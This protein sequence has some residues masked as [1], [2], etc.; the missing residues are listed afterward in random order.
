MPAHKEIGL[1]ETARGRGRCAGFDG[2][3]DIP[4]VGDFDVDMIIGNQAALCR[5][6][7]ILP[8]GLNVFIPMNA[9]ANAI[10][11]LIAPQHPNAVIQGRPLAVVEGHDPIQ[12][13]I[14][15][16][17]AQGHPRGIPDRMIC[18]RRPEDANVGVRVIGQPQ[19]AGTILGNRGRFRGRE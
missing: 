2:R 15:S 14:I 6:F 5:Y 18:R 7:H 13:I 1:V 4:I 3:Q 9:E 17:S 19:F 8:G 12:I 11:G 16:D 10:G